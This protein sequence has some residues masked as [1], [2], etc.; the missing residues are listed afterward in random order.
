MC[1]SVCVVKS[2]DSFM[3]LHVL[4]FCLGLGLGLGLGVLHE[5]HGGHPGETC[6]KRL[7]RMFVWWPGITQHIEDSVKKLH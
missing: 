2:L 6:M 3:S 1:V 4:A 5:L 7:A